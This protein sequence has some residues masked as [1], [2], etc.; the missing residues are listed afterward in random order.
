MLV[1]LKLACFLGLET[2][3]SMKKKT[4]FIV[5]VLSSEFKCSSVK[6]KWH[7]VIESSAKDLSLKSHPRD[8]HQ[9]LTYLYGRYLKYLT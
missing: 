4:R 3:V 2:C 9:K 1:S 6:K 8:Y 5:L 7:C